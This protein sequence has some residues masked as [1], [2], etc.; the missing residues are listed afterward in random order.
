MP[1]ATDWLSMNENLEQV[2]GVRRQSACTLHASS[3]WTAAAGGRGKSSVR[4]AMFI[5]T[6]PVDRSS[7]VGAALFVIWSDI[8]EVL[9]SLFMPLLRSLL[10]SCG[11]GFYKHGAP[12][13]ACAAWVTE[14]ACKV[15][16]RAQRR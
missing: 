15:Q 5:A 3:D 12:N 2:Y 1:N 6:G 8:P 13:G 16:G 9:K 14:D 10:G 7:S 4:S 11:R